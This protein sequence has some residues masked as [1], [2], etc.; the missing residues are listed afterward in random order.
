M[1]YENI[2]SK[3]QLNLERHKEYENKV[4]KFFRESIETVI[5]FKD[6]YIK[7][8]NPNFPTMFPVDIN[9]AFYF[10]KALHA[11]V[12]NTS[13]K[14]HLE[15]DIETLDINFEFKLNNKMN[16]KISIPKFLIFVESNYEDNNNDKKKFMKDLFKAINSAID[17]EYKYLK[18]LDV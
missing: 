9:N 17:E 13:F 15:E 2:I 18:D 12:L 3:N 1:M 7:Y 4:R 14:T 5:D 8:K 11:W 16:I 6:E 10:D